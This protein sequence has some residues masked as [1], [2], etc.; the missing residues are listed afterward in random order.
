MRIYFPSC[1]VL[2]LVGTLDLENTLWLACN[3][4]LQTRA[5]LHRYGVVDNP[6]CCLCGGI[7]TQQHLLFECVETKNIWHKM[8]IWMQNQH[9]AVSWIQEIDWII[10]NMKGKGSRATI[11]KLAV[12]KSV[13]EI[14]RH[15]NDKCFENDVH[16]QKVEEKIIDNIVYRWWLNSKH[17]QIH[18]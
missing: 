18:S 13:Y 3:E 8:L 6:N 5:K 9:V 10:Q 15:R 17:R 1:F 11:L 12:T 4:R 7:E 14:W 16:T 2:S